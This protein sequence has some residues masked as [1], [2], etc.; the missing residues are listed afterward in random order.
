MKEKS[1]SFEITSRSEEMKQKVLDAKK[2]VYQTLGVEEASFS[3]Q[4][5]TKIK[6]KLMESLKIIVA[7][8]MLVTP[9]C[10]QIEVDKYGEVPDHA[11]AVWVMATDKEVDNG[12]LGKAYLDKQFFRFSDFYDF[13]R[14]TLHE[15]GHAFEDLCS[16]KTDSYPKLLEALDVDENNKLDL[17]LYLI[18]HSADKVEFIADMFSYY[19][20]Y[21]FVREAIDVGFDTPKLR[22]VAGWVLKDDLKRNLNFVKG[23]I[24]KF[25][26]APIDFINK[27]LK[28]RQYSSF[29][30][31][32]AY[33]IYRRNQINADRGFRNR[34]YSEDRIPQLESKHDMTK[35]ERFEYADLMILYLAKSCGID[36][37]RIGL[38]MGCDTFKRPM[39]YIPNEMSEEECDDE[40]IGTIVF[41][42]DIFE[43]DKEEFISRIKVGLGALRDS[44]AVKEQI[45]FHIAKFRRNKKVVV[46]ENE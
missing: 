29:Y 34:L 1:F 14:V 42:S 39:S 36:P 19:M 22:K 33:E 6:L 21:T 5:L 16:L 2:F 30:S 37:E 8:K 4:E 27:K 28:R 31:T 13:I 43:V 10:I 3:E 24:L 15:L 11:N 9:D 23:N 38:V 26:T 12:Q 40:I 17:N 25:V 35:Q 44:H 7:D 20:L 32:N 46:D 18:K 45:T 41:G